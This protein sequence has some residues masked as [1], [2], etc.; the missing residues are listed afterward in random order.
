MKDT[1]SA[2]WRCTR[3]TENPPCNRGG[4]LRKSCS[5]YTVAFLSRPKHT[6]RQMI[7]CL[8]TASKK[9]FFVKDRFV[10]RFFK[11]FLCHFVLVFY[12]C[13]V[14]GNEYGQHENL[15]YIKVVFCD[16]RAP[17]PTRL[18][19]LQMQKNIPKRKIF[20]KGVFF[21]DKNIHMYSWQNILCRKS[22]LI[23]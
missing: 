6:L 5:H 19:F 1:T 18:V 14:A 22:I 9:G 3:R 21:R 20:I 23:L 2:I 4:R 8:Y 16:K 13:K 7:F 17:P 10:T 12:K 11:I 15:F